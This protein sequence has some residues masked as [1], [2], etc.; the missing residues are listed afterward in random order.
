MQSAVTDVLNLCSVFSLV[1]QL[2]GSRDSS[3]GIVTRNGLDGPGT[4]SRWGG[5]R[6]SAPVQ[7]GPGAHSAF[8]KMD[9][10]SFLGVKCLR[11]GVELPT[12]PN[13]EVP[14]IPLLPL[15]VFIICSRLNFTFNRLT[16][17]DPYMGRTEPLTSK[18]CISYIYSTNIGTEYFKHAL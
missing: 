2:Y 16:P 5:S 8:Y 6:S 9:T 15:W 3:V 10:G 7:N 4:E 18:R 12:P 13:P 17:N 11:R 14:E 1:V